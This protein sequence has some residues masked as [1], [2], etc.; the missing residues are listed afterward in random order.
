MSDRPCSIIYVRYL[1]NV[2]CWNGFPLKQ[3]CCPAGEDLSDG[4]GGSLRTDIPL[5]VTVFSPRIGNSWHASDW[6]VL[7]AFIGWGWV[8]LGMRR[9][10]RL[11]ISGKP[12]RGRRGH[13]L[14]SCLHHPRKKNIAWWSREQVKRSLETERNFFFYLYEAFNFLMVCFWCCL[15]CLLL[16]S[17]PLL[18]SHDRQI[19]L[20]QRL[21]SLMVSGLRAKLILM[22]VQLYRNLRTLFLHK[23]GLQHTL[24]EKV[25]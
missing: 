18:L 5:S 21:F 19:I 1:C 17:L 6:L 10:V 13:P 15:Y 4:R 16:S 2:Q 23:W 7:G 12:I 3:L 14:L 9:V 8:G 24:T 20:L 25:K 22:A 11:R